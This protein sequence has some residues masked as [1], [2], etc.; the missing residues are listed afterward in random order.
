MAEYVFSGVVEHED[1]GMS[2]NVTSRPRERV[3]RCRDCAYAQNGGTSCLY[4]SHKESAWSR[5]VMPDVV[6]DGFCAWGSTR[7]VD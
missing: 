7:E 3:V 5:P 6:P 2:V 1:G 4:W